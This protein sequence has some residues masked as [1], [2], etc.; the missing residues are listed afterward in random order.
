MKKLGVVL[1][2]VCVITMAAT[3]APAF[4][5]WAPYMGW[6]G[7]GSSTYSGGFWPGAYASSSTYYGQPGIAG[8]WSGIPWGTSSSSGWWSG[9]CYSSS[10]RY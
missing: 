3:L 1:A 9:G 8:Y 7:C 10:Y 6:G 5:A 2:L 4:Y